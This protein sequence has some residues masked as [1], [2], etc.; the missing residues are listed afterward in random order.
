[1]QVTSQESVGNRKER[2]HF[3]AVLIAQGRQALDYLSEKALRSVKVGQ[4]LT[5]VHTKGTLH[6]VMG[7]K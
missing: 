5:L 6:S 7:L 2:E 4:L 3:K 1:M